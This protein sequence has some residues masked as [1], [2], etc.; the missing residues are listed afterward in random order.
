[1]PVCEC[2]W[3]DSC[4]YGVSEI[5][6]PDVCRLAIRRGDSN[7]VLTQVQSIVE[8]PGGTASFRF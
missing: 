1:M 8:G 6:F 5:S 7:V 4:D 2:V 3:V